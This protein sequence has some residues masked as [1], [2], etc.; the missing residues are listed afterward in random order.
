VPEPPEASIL[1]FKHLIAMAATPSRQALRRWG[2]SLGIRLPAAIAR[3]A[4]LQED[5]SVE[6]SVVEGGVLIRPVQPRLSLA[7]RLAAYEP[8]PGEPTEAMAF[9]P[10]GAEVV[11]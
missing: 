6:L 9:P 1:L 7:E 5:Q 2:N 3:E 10:L 11:E 4:Q 8:M